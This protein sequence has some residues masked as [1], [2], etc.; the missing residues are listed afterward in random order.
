MQS[1]CLSKWQELLKIS[2]SFNLWVWQKSRS[3][4]SPRETWGTSR[5]AHMFLLPLLEPTAPGYF[6]A[7]P[8]VEFLVFKCSIHQIRGNGVELLWH[9][10]G[11]SLL[12]CWCNAVGNSMRMLWW[13]GS[14]W[15]PAGKGALCSIPSVLRNCQW[16]DY[17]FI[18]TTN[19]VTSYLLDMSL[20]ADV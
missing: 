16:L 11:R 3:D 4:P 12:L 7:V 20:R 5:A 18:N 8:T 13:E 19:E 6:I 2:Y 9:C 15:W 17:V 1:I 10:R 14:H